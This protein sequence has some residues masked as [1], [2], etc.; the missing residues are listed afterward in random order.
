MA[1]PPIEPGAGRAAIV[2]HYGRE[3]VADVEMRIASGDASTGD[4]AIEHLGLAF[5]ISTRLTSWLAVTAEPTVEPTLPTRRVEVAQAVPAGLS[6]MGLD[7]RAGQGHDVPTFAAQDRT[8][9]I[10][11][12][13]TVRG[14]DGDTPKFLSQQMAGAGSYITSDAGASLPLLE[15]ISSAA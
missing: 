11:T 8:V 4:S 7:L 9:V 6:V 13:G 12:L 5:G 10:K 15:D 2:G 14:A 1:L 3:A